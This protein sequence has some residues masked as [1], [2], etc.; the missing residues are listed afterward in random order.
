MSQAL[1]SMFSCLLSV[2]PTLTQEAFAQYQ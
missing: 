2:Y 1:P